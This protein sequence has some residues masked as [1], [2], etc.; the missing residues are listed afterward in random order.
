MTTLYIRLPVVVDD[1]D[2]M[3]C[4]A[5]S[6]ATSRDGGPWCRVFGDLEYE[7]CPHRNAACISATNAAIDAEIAASVSGMRHA[8]DL[9]DE[10]G[11]GVSE[12][13]DRALVEAEIAR[14]EA[15]KVKP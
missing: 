10:H 2:P 8:M 14:L 12:S 15:R 6:Y 5:C 4:G 3:R 1:A 13:V 11:T 7:V 9:I